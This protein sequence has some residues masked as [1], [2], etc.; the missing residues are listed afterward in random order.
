MNPLL[1]LVLVNLLDQKKPLNL[2][3]YSLPPLPN[4]F[5][6]FN[7]EILLDKLQS[8]SNT[9]DKVN[10]LSHVIREPKA[11][12]APQSN[13][14]PLPAAL[15]QME[16]LAPLM[17]MAQGVDMKALMQNIGPIMNMLG[18]SQEK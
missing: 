1:L 15:D 9:L 6:N 5:D 16:Q 10:R 2:R 7:L 4:Y 12:N 3:K 8:A 13:D 14:S 18:N 11:L 17:Q